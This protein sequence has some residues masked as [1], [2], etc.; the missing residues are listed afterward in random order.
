MTDTV[1]WEFI[2]RDVFPLLYA[3]LV[4]CGI[5][6]SYLLVQRSRSRGFRIAN[7]CLVLTVVICLITRVV[8]DLATAFIVVGA[9]T[10]VRLRAAIEDTR[11]FGFL[12]LAVAAGLGAGE[13]RYEIVLVGA[14]LVCILAVFLAPP[15]PEGFEH[16]VSATIPNSAIADARASITAAGTSHA[17]RLRDSSEGRTSLRVDFIGRQGVADTFLDWLRNQPDVMDLRYEVESVG[18]R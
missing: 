3:A 8:D 7:A 14:I 2:V 16:R 13:R 1:P 15:A 9:L 4:G 12:V 6:L 17:L 18:E 11:E 5:G 10:L